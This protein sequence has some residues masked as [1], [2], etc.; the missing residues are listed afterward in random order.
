MHVLLVGALLCLPALGR[1]QTTINYSDL[2]NNSSP[3]TTTA[4]PPYYLPLYLE[5]LSG[6][7]TQSG[8]IT[9]DGGIEKTGTGTL[10]LSGITSFTGE[11]VVAAGT[12]IHTSTA[13]LLGDIQILGSGNGVF[14][15]DGA[16]D[17]AAGLLGTGTF[18]K[19]GADDFTLSG[20]NT[21][22][23]GTAVV[24][25]GL[26][27]LASANALNNAFNSGVR[28]TFTG[29]TLRFT[30]ANTR[31]YSLH[32]ANSTAAIALDTNGENV[33]FA[34]AIA[35]TN[36]GGLTKLG[37]GTLTLAGDNAYSGTTTIS[38]GTLQ[39]GNGGSTGSI[40]GNIVN[41]GALVL[42]RSDAA[43]NLTG[44]I[45]GSGSLTHG[46]SGAVTLS[47]VNTFSGGTTLAAGTLVLGSANALNASAGTIA[48]SG[49]TLRYG[50]GVTTDYSARFSAA[51]N[52]DY[53]IHTG[54]QN[55]TFASGLT[56]SGGSLTKLGDG[57]LTLTGTNTYTGATTLAGGTLALG[58][59][60]A[61]NSDAE[62]LFS[63][64]TLQFSAANTRDYSDR[65]STTANQAYRLDT[66][67][68]SVTFATALT[69]S[70]G[71]LT[72]IGAGTLTLT[73]AN[74]Y[75][76]ATTVSGGTLQIGNGGTSGSLAGDVSIGSGATLSFNRSDDSTHSGRISGNGTLEKLGAGTLTLTGTDA[77]GGSTTISNGTLQIGDG[78]A[79]GALTGT[80]NVG[81]GAVLA[82]NSS[83]NFTYASS[84]TG[85]GSVRQLGSGT[86]TLSGNNTYTGTTV[87]GGGVVAVNSADAIGSG[88]AISFTGGTL[89][90][91]ATNTDFSSRFAV[92]LN[93]SYNI[94]TN[95]LNVTFATALT[96]GGGTLTKLGAGTL[97]LTADATFGGASTVSAGTLQLGNGGTAG[98][99]AGNASVAAGATLA[100]NRSDNTTYTGVISGDG[101][102]TKL[103]SGTLT[104]T[105]SHTYTGTTTISAGTLQIGNGGGATW[106][107]T[108][109]IVNHAALVLH[110]NGGQTIANT[111]SGSGSLTKLGNNTVTLT[112]NNS[113][114][115]TTTIDAGTLALEAGVYSGT[116]DGAG[117]LTKT[118]AGTVTLTGNNTYSGSTIVFAGTLQLGNGGS[119][120]S[121]AGDISLFSGAT[122]ALNRT[123]TYAGTFSGAGTVTK[124]GPGTLT[125]SGANSHTGGTTLADGT[126]ALGS[127][128]ALGSLGTISFTG[129]TLQFS[130]QNTTDYSGRF[131]SAAGQQYRVDT[132]GENVT[133][134]SALTSSGSTFTKSGAGTLT[135]VQGSTSTGLTTVSGGT[136]QLGNGGTSGSLAGNVSIASGATF[137][138]NRSNDATYAGALSGSGAFVKDGAG[139]LTLSGNSSH[140]GGTTVAAGTL[141]IGA[142]FM[143]A[144][145]NDYSTG[146]LTG[147]IVNHGVVDFNRV[148]NYTFAG[149]ISGSGSVTHSGAGTLTLTGDNSYTGTTTL[150]AGTLELGSA[151]AL[152]SSGDL[153]LNGG[154][155]RFTAA[156]TT[157][158]SA[159][160]SG[161]SQ[162]YYL[163]TNGQHV[164]LAHDF[165]RAGSYL[166]KSGEGSLTLSGHTTLSYGSVNA[167]SLIVNGTLANDGLFV[168]PAATLGG[169]GTLGG[170]T[171]IYTGA[172]L[173]PGNS[174]GTL[175]FTDGLTLFEGAI[176]NFELG[177][178]SD[179]IR[180]TGG[181]LTGPDSAGGLILNLADSGGFTAASYTLFD[182]TGAT[183]S[184]F[185]TSDFSFGN[186]IA[187]YTYS[188]ALVGSTLQLTA[189]A[190]SAVPEPSTYAAFAGL[191]ALALMIVRRRPNSAR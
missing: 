189:V 69:S 150:S 40:A 60:Q 103:G 191:A 139:I 176:L 163:D 54:G 167:G 102:I 31:D 168:G 137:A 162:F 24:D 92:G 53:R 109:A 4:E 121:V 13:P 37:S 108:G 144:N 146:S 134:A 57:T 52:Q 65:F 23:A 10:T 153:V 149:H 188:L 132:G 34:S 133:F 68:Q 25:G 42:D 155:L 7:A 117:A 84:L 148:E 49:G 85:G 118:G 178:V 16:G 45:S 124:A 180:V 67:G 100:F 74:T 51:A 159:R 2:E 185:T 175:T 164:T 8:Q 66:N 105:G 110:L 17:Y 78:G 171:T 174:P 77:F 129:G 76:G 128:G 142:S 101:A 169:S 160:F 20:N 75:G 170:H 106:G 183:T 50:D 48:F 177:T 32:L 83:E 80:V 12:L 30:A 173:A 190:A 147:N 130:N 29:G 88:G 70:G 47:G 91:G 138:V 73:A 127:S 104:L 141:R 145:Y 11:T 136:L 14:V 15:R 166:D 1:A 93:Q 5:V 58:S 182:F 61:L 89:R 123:G 6:S 55:V 179:L 28:I 44:A 96:S 71:S 41:H 186:T 111:L 113:Y 140:T 59:P 122:L 131:S 165:G 3:L 87:L 72:K 154:T 125:L 43:L 64:G 135:L 115:G 151:G 152:G 18:K 107:A 36:T 21:F 98:A 172:T 97:T 114:T 86:L 22:F 157:D 9:G 63:G 62:I 90:F 158:Y 46:G 181:T 120:G 156:N 184:S 27:T 95:G 126:L 56:S 26:L 161:G 38:A 35:A 112:G 79:A 143:D 187:G 82:F 33:T 119:T 81:A 99:L 116:I 94:D 39:L 19:T